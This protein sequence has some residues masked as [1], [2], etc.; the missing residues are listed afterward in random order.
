MKIDLLTQF[1][2][3]WNVFWNLHHLI[4]SFI[5]EKQSRRH[6]EPARSRVINKF[7]DKIPPRT[8]SSRDKN[9]IK[10]SYQT[11]SHRERSLKCRKI[12][13]KTQ[14]YSLIKVRQRRLLL[15]WLLTK[16][17]NWFLLFFSLEKHSESN[18]SQNTFS[19]ISWCSLKLHNPEIISYK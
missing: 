13:W 16:V 12:I 18:C 19:S 14:F 4:T 15:D 1:E 2:L 11:S 10:R 8:E 17:F 5:A 7:D 3:L 9:N 6:S